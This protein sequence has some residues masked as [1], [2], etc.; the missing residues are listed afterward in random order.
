MRAKL[1]QDGN[2]ASV[3]GEDVRWTTQGARS[4]RPVGHGPLELAATLAGPTVELDPLRVPSTH[5]EDQLS[6][7]VRRVHPNRSDPHLHYQFTY[8]ISAYD[9]WLRGWPI[10]VCVECPEYDSGGNLRS[11]YDDETCTGVWHNDFKSTCEACT[12]NNI[13]GQIFYKPTKFNIDYYRTST[14]LNLDVDTRFPVETQLDGFRKHGFEMPPSTGELMN[15]M[16]DAQRRRLKAQRETDCFTNKNGDINLG[17]DGQMRR[18]DRYV[19]YAMTM[20]EA[21]PLET[22]HAP[23][24]S[25]S[26]GYQ[27][28]PDVDE[29]DAEES[30]DYLSDNSTES[31]GSDA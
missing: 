3:C 5:R 22:T 7:W 1:L 12:L 26:D 19:H 16:A 13:L 10:E 20:Q 27:H 9:R 29:V 21:M 14:F 11:G 23:S 6:V 31:D 24:R 18:T 25:R 15:L 4:V 2:V 8:G 28:V 30:M 17:K